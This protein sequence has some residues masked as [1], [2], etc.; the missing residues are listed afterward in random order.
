MRYD[1]KQLG[2]SDKKKVWLY[3]KFIKIRRRALNHAAPL[4]S[5][6]AGLV[7]LPAAIHLGK[8]GE[9]AVISATIAIL[10]VSLDQ[11]TQRRRA[12]MDAHWIQPTRPRDTGPLPRI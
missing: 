2:V 1:L 10:F 11:I 6:V 4:V 3:I 7:I 12:R 9:W 5:I 8:V